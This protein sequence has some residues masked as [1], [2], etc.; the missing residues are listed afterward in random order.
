MKF[1]ADVAATPF[2][3]ALL[4]Y[5]GI[6]TGYTGMFCSECSFIYFRQVRLRYREKQIV[7]LYNSAV[8]SEIGV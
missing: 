7:E 6:C 5:I 1:Q 2:L 3:V 8:A 4:A